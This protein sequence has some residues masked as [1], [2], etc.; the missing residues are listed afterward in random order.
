[1]PLGVWWGQKPKRIFYMANSGKSLGSLGQ[2]GF[3]ALCGTFKS[4]YLP[5]LKKDSKTNLKIFSVGLWMY[6]SIKRRDGE[7]SHGGYNF[8]KQGFNSRG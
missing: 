3:R 2:I 1:M 7:K 4:T 5:M 6:Q 8:A